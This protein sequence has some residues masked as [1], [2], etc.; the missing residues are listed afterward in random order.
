[1]LALPKYFS[2]FG[3][4]AR[5]VCNEGSF[6]C[7]VPVCAG[8]TIFDFTCHVGSTVFPPITEA[9]NSGRKHYAEKVGLDRAES[10]CGYCLTLLVT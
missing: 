2:S 7:V 9:M 10:A 4:D 5:T 6:K 1:M 8:S 3:Q